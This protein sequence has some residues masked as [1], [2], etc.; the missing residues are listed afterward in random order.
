MGRLDRI[1]APGHGGGFHFIEEGAA[2]AFEPAC[3]RGAVPFRPAV[4]RPAGVQR[5]VDPV[6]IRPVKEGLVVVAQ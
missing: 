4:E 2:A 1:A 6:R 5:H 3:R